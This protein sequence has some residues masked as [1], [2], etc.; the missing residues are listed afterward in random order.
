MARHLVDFTRALLLALL[1]TTGLERRLN[2]FNRM[3]ICH[4]GFSGHIS[5]PDKAI[6]KEKGLEPLSGLLLWIMQ[7]AIEYE[8]IR[9]QNAY[10][11]SIIEV[12]GE[13]PDD[14]GMS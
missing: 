13:D 4:V 1:V 9:H 12:L 14:W 6:A 10:R 5:L 8:K 7:P 3:I 11:Q 2:V